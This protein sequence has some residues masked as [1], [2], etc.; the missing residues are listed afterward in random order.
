LSTFEHKKKLA[1]SF[2]VLYFLRFHFLILAG[3]LQLFLG[4]PSLFQGGNACLQRGV[5]ALSCFIAKVYG[6]RSWLL[7]VLKLLVRDTHPAD[8]LRGDIWL[9]SGQSLLPHFK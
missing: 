9:P 7:S 1:D 4:C 5:Y 2:V 6:H 8:S 3:T